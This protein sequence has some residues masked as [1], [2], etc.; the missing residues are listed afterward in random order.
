[1]IVD[2]FFSQVWVLACFILPNR[3]M[4]CG[5]CAGFSTSGYQP[6]P[7]FDSTNAPSGWPTILSFAFFNCFLNSPSLSFLP[8]GV[9]C[10]F[11]Q[12][13]IS[14]CRT[15]YFCSQR[16]CLHVSNSRHCSSLRHPDIT[17]RVW[18]ENFLVVSKIDICR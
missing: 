2:F 14:A 13:H 8:P 12:K 17:L 11:P 18:N 5:V 3:Y 6:V 7:I 9:F 10:T 4:L 16:W 1:M 15:P